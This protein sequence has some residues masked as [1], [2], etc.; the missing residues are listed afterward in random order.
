MEESVRVRGGDGGG[1]GPGGIGITIRRGKIIT[2][3]V[4]MVSTTLWGGR[5]GRKQPR[6]KKRKKKKKK[7]IFPKGAGCFCPDPI[8]SRFGSRLSSGGGDT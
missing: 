2:K 3:K 6:R 7:K 4:I 1:G 5:L 8:L